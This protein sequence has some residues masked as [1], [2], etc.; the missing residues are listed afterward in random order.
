MRLV[1]RRPR[2][3]QVR[4]LAVAVPSRLVTLCL[5]CAVRGRGIQLADPSRQEPLHDCGARA[6][7]QAGP[8]LRGTQDDGRDGA[9]FDKGLAVEG[10]PGP[11]KHDL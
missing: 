10:G 11:P 8:E 3:R 4:Y 9:P 7:I 1:P 2:K 5:A 6:L